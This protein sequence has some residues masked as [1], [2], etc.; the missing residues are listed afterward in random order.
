MKTLTRFIAVVVIAMVVML[1]TVQEGFGASDVKVTKP[2]DTTV[3]GDFTQDGFPFVQQFYTIE[4]SLFDTSLW[5]ISVSGVAELGPSQRLYI[6]VSTGDT[7]TAPNVDTLMLRSSFRW[8]GTSYIPFSFTW[9]LREYVLDTDVS[10]SVGV[11][12]STGSSTRSVKLTDL[13]IESSVIQQM[14]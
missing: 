7:G 11:F 2:A 3:T 13:R 5:Y 8:G 10:D 1:A 14:K 12:F 9:L 6:A 4:D